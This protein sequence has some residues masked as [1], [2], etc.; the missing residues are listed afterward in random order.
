[1]TMLIGN[2]EEIGFEFALDDGAIGA[3]Q[4]IRLT[5]HIAGCA[6]PYD[7]DFAYADDVSGELLFDH[8]RD[9]ARLVTDIAMIDRRA[10]TARIL[11]S[12]SDDPENCEIDIAGRTYRPGDFRIELIAPLFACLFQGRTD[13]YLCVITSEGEYLERVFP[14]GH[15]SALRAATSKSIRS[16]VAQRSRE[17]RDGDQ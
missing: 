6:I 4:E 9:D 5:V 15:M 11:A 17:N 13:E 3:W 8:A 16:K 12:I 10:L 14:I 7:N 2:R 1:M